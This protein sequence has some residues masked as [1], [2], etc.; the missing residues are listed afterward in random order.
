MRSEL[1][2]KWSADGTRLAFTADWQ[3]PPNL[4][5]TD[6]SGSE[7]RV[8]VP[9]DRTQQYLGGWT[10]DGSRVVYSKV[11]EK[12]AR[13]LWVVDTTSGERRAILATAFDEAQPAVAANGS[14]LAYI[15]NASGRQEV[16]LRG[17]PDS[18]WQTRISSDGARALAWRA[19]GRELFYV[20]PSGAFMAVSLSPGPYGRSRRRL[21]ST[22]A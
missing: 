1:D 18:T 15:S 3:G 8:L 9:F 2:P 20:D 21:D 16:Y 19:D 7:P 10:P 22:A 12:S 5:V 11:T 4:Y 17:F 14:W 6:L 13:D